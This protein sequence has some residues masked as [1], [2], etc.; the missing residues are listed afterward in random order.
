MKEYPRTDGRSYSDARPLSVELNSLKSTPSCRLTLGGPT[1]AGAVAERR[2]SV[3]AAVYFSSDNKNRNTVG[4]YHKPTFEVYVRPPTGPVRGY[5]RGIECILMKALQDFVDQS[6]LGKLLVSVRI[7]ILE[8]G[9]GLLALCLNALVTCVMVA[10]LK[11]R[12]IPHA[13]QLG[14]VNRNGAGGV[15]VDP[16]PSELSKDCELGVTMLCTPDTGR[17]SLTSIDHGRGGYEKRLQGSMESAARH[18]AAMRLQQISDEYQRHFERVRV[19]FE[20]NIA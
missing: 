5:I 20:A 17:I 12:E 4:S 6:S 10:G 19:S 14:V 1:P 11:L 16:S 2:T 15:L 18:V 9:S 13:V 3:L 7:Q 8:E